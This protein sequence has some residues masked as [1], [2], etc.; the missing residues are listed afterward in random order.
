MNKFNANLRAAENAKAH[1]KAPQL[2][3]AYRNL[4]KGASKHAEAAARGT[5]WGQNKLRH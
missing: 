3:R 4:Q 1:N 5:N 2:E